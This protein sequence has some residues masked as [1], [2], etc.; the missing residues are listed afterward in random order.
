MPINQATSLKLA[1][2]NHNP[3]ITSAVHRQLQDPFSI[4][5]D[6]IP[7]FLKTLCTEMKLLIPFSTRHLFFRLTALGVERSIYFLSQFLKSKYGSI[8]EEA[9]VGKSQRQKIKVSR[10]EII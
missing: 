10:E 5:A 1:N 7:P 2:M 6:E 4:I 8:P 9:K 3:K